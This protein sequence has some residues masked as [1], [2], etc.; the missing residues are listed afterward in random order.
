MVWA[1]VM[2][3]LGAARSETF[4]SRGEVGGGHRR[5]QGREKEEGTREGRWRRWRREV[6]VARAGVIWGEVLGG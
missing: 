4:L 3:A 5:A 2:G 1:G 6:D